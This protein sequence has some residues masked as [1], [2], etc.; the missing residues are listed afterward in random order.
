M[1]ARSKE[2]DRVSIS[3]V[4]RYA[5]V[6]FIVSFAGWCFEKVGRYI[7]YNSITDRGFLT[8]PICPIYGSSILLIFFV[9]G[10]PRAPRWEKRDCNIPPK[11]V[12]LNFFIYF[13]LSALISSLVELVTGVLFKKA[14]GI[15]LWNY[16]DRFLNLGGYISLGYGLLWGALITLF[17]ASVWDVMMCFTERI[18]VSARVFMGTLLCSVAMIDL[19]FN[20]FYLLKTGI[21]FNFL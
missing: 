12:V 13:L 10:T 6:F 20:L 21:H 17:M 3:E 15:T 16:G 4:S 1:R 14:L 19:L 7:V 9:M 11:K 8:M 2:N 5:T 18:G